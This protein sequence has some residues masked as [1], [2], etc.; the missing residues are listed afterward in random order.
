MNYNKVT[1]FRSFIW[2]KKVQN[3]FDPVERHFY[4]GWSQKILTSIKNVIASLLRVKE[5]SFSSA[6]GPYILIQSLQVFF[7]IQAV[8]SIDAD[9]EI[10]MNPF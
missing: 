3:I 6:V 7:A 5:Q 9:I 2:F 1:I 10:Q 4:V 8:C